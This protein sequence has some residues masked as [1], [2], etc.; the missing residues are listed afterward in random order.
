MDVLRA[1]DAKGRLSDGSLGLQWLALSL[2]GLEIDGTR[3]MEMEDLLVG[4][5]GMNSFEFYC[6]GEKTRSTRRSSSRRGEADLVPLVRSLNAG[7]D[8]LAISL[9]RIINSW[10]RSLRSVGL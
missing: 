10:S 1:V 8:L 4:M 2:M 6:P 3:R 5:Q 9:P 7:H